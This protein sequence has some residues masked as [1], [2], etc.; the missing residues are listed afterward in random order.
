MNGEKYPFLETGEADANLLF[1]SKMQE[2][3]RVGCLRGAFHT[4]KELWRDWIDTRPEWKTQEF[5]NELSDL[6]N[7]LRESGPLKSFAAMQRFCS[8]HPQAKMSDSRGFYA[9]RID[10]ARHRYYLRFFPVKKEYHFYIWC[11]RTDQLVTG[12]PEP[13]YSLVYGPNADKRM[14]AAVRKARNQNER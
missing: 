2:Q 4:D 11:Y 9:F 5:R 10:T 7:T 14:R 13:D 8:R 3:A 12:R 1:V 6:V